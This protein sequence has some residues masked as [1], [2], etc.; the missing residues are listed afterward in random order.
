MKALL[1]VADEFEDLELFTVTSILRRALPVTIASL[2]STIVTSASGVK[3]TADKRLAELQISDY[4]ILILPSFDGMENSQKLMGT[5]MA[6][7]KENK[8]ITA[9]SRAPL[10]LAKA[11]V[12]ENKIATVYPGLE[13]RIPRPRDARIVVD[14]NIITSRAP[15]D[16]AELALKLV[17]I[18]KGKAAEKNL[19]ERIFP[20]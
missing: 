1:I 7:H 12:L 2:S 5:I 10:I 14:G 3:I 19:R 18:L 15:S 4:T 17:E 13:S 6:F 9:M 20:S 8:L 16:S 11:G